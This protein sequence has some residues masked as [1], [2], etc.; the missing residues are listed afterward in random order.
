MLWIWKST[1]PPFET[2]LGGKG[3]EWPYALL[4]EVLS[5]QSQKLCAL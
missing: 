5:G 2:S 4:S 1:V 3:L